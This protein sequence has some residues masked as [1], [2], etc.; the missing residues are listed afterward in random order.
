MGG[1]DE[2][3]FWLVRQRRPYTCQQM[4]DFMATFKASLARANASSVL[5][6]AFMMS[7]FIDMVSP[8]LGFFFRICSAAL[9]PRLYCFSS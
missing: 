7:A 4:W 6:W 9:S 3:K 1:G 2:E 8:C 5:P